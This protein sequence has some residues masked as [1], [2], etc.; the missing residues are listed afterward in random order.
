M[1]ASAPASSQPP[2]LPRH[3]TPGEFS[4]ALE[5]CGITLHPKTVRERCGLPDGDAERIRVNPNF[6]GRYY[7]PGSELTRLATGEKTTNRN[8]HE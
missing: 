4:A 3:Y 8:G 1:N 2:P 6:P 5:A 7:I